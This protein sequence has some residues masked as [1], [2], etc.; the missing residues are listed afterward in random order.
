MKNF[1]HVS[2]IIDGL[3]QNLSNKG[4]SREIK[5][6]LLWN[7]TVG[8]LL[9]KRSRITKLENNILFILVD[10]NVWLQEFILQ[11]SKIISRIN[12]HLSKSDKISD[13]IFSLSSKRIDF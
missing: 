5:I 12:K 9:N 2:K 10:N 1:T 3:I 11:K 4:F 13:I 8:R 7:K 6:A